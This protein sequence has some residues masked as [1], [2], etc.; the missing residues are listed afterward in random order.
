VFQWNNPVQRFDFWFRGFPT[1]FQTLPAG[2][3][4]GGYYFFQT[5]GATTIPMVGGVFVLPSPGGSF[6]ATPPGAFG[7]LWSGHPKT[8]AQMNSLTGV[9]AIFWWNNPAQQFNFW[10]RGFPDN[11]QTLT[12]L[13]PGGFYFFQ[14]S[15]GV[16]VPMD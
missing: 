13:Q 7:Q 6:V 12:G 2:L 1:P 11:F 16:T 5:I 4:P 8:I 3:Q 10:F 15:G 9:S 14:T